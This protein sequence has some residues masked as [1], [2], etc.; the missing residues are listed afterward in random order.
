MPKL[1]HLNE[2]TLGLPHGI[3]AGQR[4]PQ[5]LADAAA[6]SL[7]RS[8]RKGDGVDFMICLR[9]GILGAVIGIFIGI[10]LVFTLQYS[11]EEKYIEGIWTGATGM[12]FVWI[13]IGSRKT[14]I[15]HFW[16]VVKP[17]MFRRT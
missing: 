1:Q 12:F 17:T 9:W 13:V 10:A 6:G 15:R 7:E 11:T 16:S 4:L 2:D 5:R 8:N 3:F 14:W